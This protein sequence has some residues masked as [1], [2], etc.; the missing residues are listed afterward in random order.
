MGVA[1][2]KD[3]SGFPPEQADELEAVAW[4]EGIS[5]SD[6]VREVISGHIVLERDREIRERLAR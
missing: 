6:A 5:V 4:A 2:R 3:R 1:A